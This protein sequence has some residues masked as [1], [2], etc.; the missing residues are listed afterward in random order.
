MLDEAIL[1]CKNRM[2]GAG[3]LLSMDQIQFQLSR[4]QSA[5]TICSAMCARSSRISGIDHNLAGEGLEANSMKAVITDL[6]QESAHLLVQ[7]SGANGYKISH[8]GGRGIMDSRP[9]QIFE[10]SN[11][12]LYSQS[13]DM[14]TRLMRKK[15]QFHLL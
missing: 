6:M 15:K 14:I 5:Y 13:A 4:I 9:F 8:V 3:N 10:G 2:V 12:M 7:V 1:H 11:E